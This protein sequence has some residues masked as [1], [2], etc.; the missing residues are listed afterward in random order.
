[1]GIEN[2]G[3]AVSINE[4]NGAPANRAASENNKMPKAVPIIDAASKIPITSPAKGLLYD[5]SGFC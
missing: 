2:K 4:V 1:M 5:E 3:L